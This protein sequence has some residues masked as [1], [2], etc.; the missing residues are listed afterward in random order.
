MRRALTIG[1]S[2]VFGLAVGVGTHRWMV[3]DVLLAGGLALSAAL[4][5]GLYVVLRP[6]LRAAGD[7][8]QTKRWQ[9]AF[10]VYVLVVTL[11]FGDTGWDTAVT[12]LLLGTAWV[13][14]LFGV[15]IVVNLPADERPQG[16]DVNA[17]A[18][19]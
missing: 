1:G 5:V 9:M 4:S 15:A 13:G 2:A 6:Y 14:M 17:D 8:W 7:Q 3:A 19:D 12:L 10:I 18:A 11:P 16:T